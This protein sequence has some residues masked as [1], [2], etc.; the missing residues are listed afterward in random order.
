MLSLRIVWN[1]ALL[2]ATENPFDIA[3]ATELKLFSSRK[4][5]RS[6]DAVHT[7]ADPF[8]FVDGEWLYVFVE[9]QRVGQPGYIEAHRTRDLKTFEALGPIL[10]QPHHLS[11][12]QVF[13]S[14]I[15]IHMV[16]ESSAAGE[17]AL[18]TFEDFP[19]GL[20]KERILLTGPYVDSTLF[21]HNGLWW[22]FATRE[23]ALE[24]FMSPALDVP[25]RLHPMNP[26]TEHPARARCGGPIIDWNGSLYRLAQDGTERYGGNLSALRI[27]EIGPETYRET[28]AFPLIFDRRVPWRSQGAHQLS[29]ARFAG[30][31]ILAVD[32]Q[33]HDLRVNRPLSLLF[34]LIG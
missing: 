5:R 17:V 34:R 30:R 31:T 23:T 21:H 33:Q 13:R 22:L 4:V 24:L 14:E 7:Q 16:P 3:G 11:Y 27:D 19:R 25:F 2:E 6:A 15:G 9:V 28:L 12:P 8:L 32:G 29:L 1:F 20:R 26:I 18:Y 10:R